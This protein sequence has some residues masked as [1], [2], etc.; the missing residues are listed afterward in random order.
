MSL[1]K[2]RFKQRAEDEAHHL[3]GFLRL[4]LEQFLG[5]HAPRD[6]PIGVSVSVIRRLQMNE[7]VTHKS[8]LRDP[9]QQCNV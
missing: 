7:R 9:F 8:K 6:V 1:L 4:F 3:E 5:M 2:H